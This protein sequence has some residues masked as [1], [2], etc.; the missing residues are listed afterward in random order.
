MKTSGSFV[1]TSEHLLEMKTGGGCLSLFGLPFFGAGIFMLLI[2]LR[3]IPLSNSADQTWWTW[4]VLGGMG[5]IFSAVGGA[6]VF[7]RSWHTIDRRQMRVWISKGLLKPMR[8]SH[9]DLHDFDKVVLR[10]EAGDSDTADK[11][12]VALL[13]SKGLPELVLVNAGSYPQGREQAALIGEFLG[14]EVLDGSSGTVQPLLSES[15]PKRQSSPPAPPVLPSRPGFELRESD[16]ELYVG[17]LGRGI[18]KARA[19]F[20][21]VPL[22]F[23][24]LF[25]FRF[26]GI[27]WAP[28][29]PVFVRAFFLGFF[30]LFFVFMPLV[31]VLQGLLKTGKPVQEL[32]MDRSGLELR[33]LAPK[34]MLKLVWEDV[35]GVDYSSIESGMSLRYGSGGRYREVDPGKI[36]PWLHRLARATG[37]EGM[38]IKTAKGLHYFG[39]GLQDEE[40]VYLQAVVNEALIRF[41]NV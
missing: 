19:L 7:G 31:G 17:V 5:I 36:P 12:P 41:K 1:R 40:L 32:R 34:R 22:V 24:M 33:D 8:A 4:L 38:V 11:Y 9:F 21:L 10:Y 30:G 37:S 6:L 18:S 2:T 20:G 39:T 16:D 14:F 13:S 15:I 25:G 3:V 23:F 28:G 27:L 26:L 35:Y 29:T